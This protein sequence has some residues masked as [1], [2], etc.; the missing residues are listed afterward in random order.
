MQ[1]HQVEWANG[2]RAGV[3]LQR[4]IDTNAWRK[5]NKRERI[6][7]LSVENRATGCASKV[8]DDDA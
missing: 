1:Y 6:Y 2:E 7:N 5:K 3:F 8:K 4:L